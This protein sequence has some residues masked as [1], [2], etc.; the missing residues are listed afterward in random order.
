ML[1]DIGANAGSYT[2]A[3]VAKYSRVIC[4]DASRLQCSVMHSRLPP[5][6]CTIIHALVSN[7]KNSK[8][9]FCRHAAGL[10]YDGINYSGISTASKEWISGKGRFA[11]GNKHNDPNMVWEEEEETR[12]VSLDE[13]VALFGEPTFIKIDVEGHEREVIYSLTKFSGTLAFEWAEEMKQETLDAIHHVSDVLGYT[14]F[15]IQ[16]EDAYAFEPKDEAFVS[17]TDLLERIESTW[18]P[19]RQEIWGML[20]CKP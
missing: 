4:V 15:Y 16:D 19:E 7:D 1:F 18:K 5:A 9:Y 8:F 10:N 3:N 12:V 13:L 11:P 20:W 17:K 2:L 14:R 6:K